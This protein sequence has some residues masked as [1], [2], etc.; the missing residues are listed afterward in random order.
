MT[1]LI[2]ISLLVDARTLCQIRYGFINRRLA[3]VSWW[4]DVAIF[5]GLIWEII[6][7]GKL[8]NF[9]AEEKI[10]ISLLIIA[11]FFRTLN[12]TAVVLYLVF[13]LPLH[14]CPTWCCFHKWLQYDQVDKTVLTNLKLS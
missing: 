10:T 4:L 9:K 11:T 1:T 8:G 7:I 2:S 6:V 13:V 14:C 5:A 12:I 3:L